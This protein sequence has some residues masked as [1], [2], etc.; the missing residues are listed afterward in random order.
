[1]TR[2][3]QTNNKLKKTKNKNYLAKKASKM[4]YKKHLT[5]LKKNNQHLEI[6]LSHLL[7]I[8]KIVLKIKLVEVDIK[9]IMVTM[10][11]QNFLPKQ[12]KYN[13]FHQQKKQGRKE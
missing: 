7:A 9:Q 12:K 3:I 2:K 8:M 11:C 6:Q 10:R 13:E 5:W 4:N 1:M